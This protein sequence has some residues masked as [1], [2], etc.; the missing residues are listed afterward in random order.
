M[1]FKKYFITFILG[2][3]LGPIGDGFHTHSQTLYYPEVLFL[4]MAWWV[5]F[6]FGSATVFIA[7]SHLTFDR[8]LKR[9][10][11]K[12]SWTTVVIGLA[13]FMFLYFCSGFLKIETI[14]MVVFLA[15]GSSMVYLTMD[16]TW[17]GAIY[18]VL[19]AL[20]G[21]LVEVAI[22][23]F[24]LFYYYEPDILGIPYW[25]PFLYIAASVAVGNF[26]R[27]LSSEI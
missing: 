26:A 10:Q 3:I 9:P 2:A 11:K 12:L 25:L 8:L 19:T 1:N 23:G 14:P 17:Q 24:D 18:C 15:I 13:S 6:L 20:I 4:K 22:S 5:P 21:S 7:H 27:K 16:R